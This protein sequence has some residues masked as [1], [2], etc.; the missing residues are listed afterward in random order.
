MTQTQ[1]ELEFI[2]KLNNF[3]KKTNISVATIC[4]KFGY[5]NSQ[6]INQFMNGSGTITSKTM[7]QIIDF[8]NEYESK[9]NKL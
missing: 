2:D 3:T 8:I 4:R 7:G 6:K 5:W 1:F 9:T